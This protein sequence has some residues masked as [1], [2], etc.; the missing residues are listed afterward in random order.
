MTLDDHTCTTNGSAVSYDSLRL[1][2]GLIGNRGK[3][4]PLLCIRWR[5]GSFCVSISLKTSNVLQ[6]I[7]IQTVHLIY[8]QLN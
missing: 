5:F 4:R 3:N 8:V 1:M 7:L 6:F 2:A